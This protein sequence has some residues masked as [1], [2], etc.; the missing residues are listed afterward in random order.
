MLSVRYSYLTRPSFQ[1]DQPMFVLPDVKPFEHQVGCPVILPIAKPQK[2]RLS[3]SRAL[4]DI[5][6]GGSREE[7]PEHAGE[8]QLISENA[9]SVE[10]GT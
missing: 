2:D 6:L 7:Y 1:I 8:H 10:G 9:Y 5:A 3:R 4:K